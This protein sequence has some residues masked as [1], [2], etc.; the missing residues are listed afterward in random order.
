MRVEGRTDNSINTHWGVLLELLVKK[1]LSPVI[2]S[3]ELEVIFEVSYLI[4]LCGCAAYLKYP[5]FE[6]IF[7]FYNEFYFWFDICLNFKL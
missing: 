4:Y 1:V 5:I 3:F 6:L 2:F 7:Y